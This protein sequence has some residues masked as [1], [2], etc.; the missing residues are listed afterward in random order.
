[1]SLLAEAGRGLAPRSGAPAWHLMAS[2]AKKPKNDF[3]DERDPSDLVVLVGVSDDRSVPL[4]EWKQTSPTI[5][6]T[7]RM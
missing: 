4:V 7:S 1:M 3:A 2:E 5:L 6:V